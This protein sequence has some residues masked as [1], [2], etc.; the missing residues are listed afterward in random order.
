MILTNLQTWAIIDESLRQT[1]D[2]FYLVPLGNILPQKISYC[3]FLNDLKLTV[4]F[5]MQFLKNYAQNDALLI[6]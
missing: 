4:Q 2:E 3:D 5:Q 1:Y 6:S